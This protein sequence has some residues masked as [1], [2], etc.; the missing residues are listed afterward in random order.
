M[1]DSE[2]LWTVA[3]KAPLSMGFSR[4][5]YWSGLPCPP[6]GDLPNSGIKPMSLSSAAMAGRF[7]TTSATRETQAY[8]YRNIRL[9]KD[10][11]GDL[12]GGLMVKTLPMQGEWVQSLVR[13]PRSCMPSGTVKKSKSFI[14]PQP[15]TDMA[16]AEETPESR[17]PRAEELLLVPSPPSNPSMKPGWCHL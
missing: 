4:Q 8:I 11:S 10:P 9:R 5:E 3:H 13:E 7:F 16:N 12:H 2:T 14:P 1:S 17:K 15:R 6:P